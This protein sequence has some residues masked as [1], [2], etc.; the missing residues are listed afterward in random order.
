MNCSCNLNFSIEKIE[1]VKCV[2]CETYQHTPCMNYFDLSDVLNEHVCYDCCGKGFATPDQCFDNLDEEQ[3][4]NLCL[5][6]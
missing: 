3:K 1:E 4:T 2:V 6:K 5:F